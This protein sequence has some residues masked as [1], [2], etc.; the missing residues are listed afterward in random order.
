VTKKRKKRVN[1]YQL[2]EAEPLPLAPL[3][4]WKI[5]EKDT[6]QVEERVRKLW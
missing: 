5:L 2:P 6:K 3:I 4:P 1:Q